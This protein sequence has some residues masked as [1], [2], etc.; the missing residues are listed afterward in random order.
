[1][2]YE[3]YCDESGI[4]ALFDKNAHRYTTI[5][6]VWLPK[7][8]RS[9]LKNQLN[10]IKHKYGVYGE[11]KWNKISPAYVEMYKQ[12]VSVFLESSQIRFRAIVVDSAK[13]DH[14]T[15]NGGSGELGFYKFYYQLI[16][17]WLHVNNAYDIFLDYKVNGY[18]YRIK[19]LEKILRYS[20]SIVRQVQTLPSDESVIIQLADILTGAVGAKFNQETRSKAKSEIIALIEAKHKIVATKKS[21]VKFNIFD[22]N[23]RKGW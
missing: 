21:E 13:L 23:L 22:I 8:Y 20:N 16:Y 19:E 1:M 11:I 18:R 12:I 6:S 17:H 10:A 3:V 7:D 5:G 2:N 4:E 14:D 15:Y 9:E